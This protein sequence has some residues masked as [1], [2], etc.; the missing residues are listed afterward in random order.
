MR[1]VTNYINESKGIP[2][3]WVTKWVDYSS[4]YGIGYVFSDNSIGVYFNDSTKILLEP[5][6]VEFDYHTRRTVENPEVHSVH[7]ITNYP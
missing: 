6:G 2:E 3:L 5:S 1:A 7:T 4:K